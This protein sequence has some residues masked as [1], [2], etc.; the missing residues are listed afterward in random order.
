MYV[1]H[2]PWIV[3]SKSIV[4]QILCNFLQVQFDVC[5]TIVL[6]VVSEQVFCSSSVSLSSD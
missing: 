2:E 5:S 1:C 4:V 6:G 3:S